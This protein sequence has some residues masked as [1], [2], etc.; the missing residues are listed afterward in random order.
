MNK[1][2]ILELT[3]HQHLV[4]YLAGFQHGRNILVFADSYTYSQTRPTLG[5]ITSPGFP[6]STK[7][8]AQNWITRQRLHPVLSNLLPEGALRALLT[9]GLKIHSGHELRFLLH[10]A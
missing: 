5:L 1:V 6:N 2:T 3:L 8:L 10:W 9:Q 7:L 4:G